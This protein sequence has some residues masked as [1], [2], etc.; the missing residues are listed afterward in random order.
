ME[1]YFLLCIL[2]KKMNELYMTNKTPELK[3]EIRKIQGITCADRD[4]AI[5]LK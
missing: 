3:R 4:S 5:R 1:F 2:D